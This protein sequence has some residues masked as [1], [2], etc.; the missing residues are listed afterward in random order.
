MNSPFVSVVIPTRN[1]C[2]WLLEAIEAVCAQAYAGGFD[3]IV[4][5]DGSTDGT[6]AAVRQ[7]VWPVSVTV[8]GGCSR[9]PA[10][11]R[12]VG[13]AAARGEVI[14]FL[15]DD[16]VPREGWLESIAT[17]AAGAGAAGG[18][19]R[20]MS[21]GSLLSEFDCI[22]WNA[23]REANEEGA[24]LSCNCAFRREVLDG[25]FDENFLL[26][27][28]EDADLAERLRRSGVSVGRAPE[29]MV[30]HRARPGIAGLVRTGFNYGRGWRY[31][32][33]KNGRPLTAASLV[34][35]IAALPFFVLSMRRYSRFG[36]YRAFVYSLFNRLSLAAA[37]TGALVGYR[38]PAAARMA[39]QEMRA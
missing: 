11:A 12:N 4:V 21:D 30:T 15:D 24:L 13:I 18:V 20:M 6:A 31:Y 32:R 33:A 7:R 26:P 9:G 37:A 29:A 10:A 8:A 3:V 5:D 39:P 2:A 1:R 17:A 38:K 35:M 36:T 28:C 34:L 27:G 25:G 22:R 19:T 16:C 14:A 23:A